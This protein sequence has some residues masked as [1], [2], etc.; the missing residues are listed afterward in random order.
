MEIIIVIAVI[1]ILA[2]V[3]IPT[4]SSIIGSSQNRVYKTNADTIYKQYVLETPKENIKKELI[5]KVG[6]NRYIVYIDGKQLR[7]IY[8][9]EQSKEELGL[10][11]HTPMDIVEG[12]ENILITSNEKLIKVKSLNQLYDGARIKIF[13]EGETNVLVMDVPVAGDVICATDTL[14]I[15]VIKLDPYNVKRLEKNDKDDSWYIIFENDDS[16]LKYRDVNE[17][18]L[19]CSETLDE[20]CQWIFKE[21]NDNIEITSKNDLN[22]LRFIRCDYVNGYNS[23][24]VYISNGYPPTIYLYNN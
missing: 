22:S 12:F 18:Y 14:N 2:A 11:P 1:A 17:H 24:F 6:E 13:Y 4:F 19:V 7:K 9:I 8:T 20:K 15:E 21:M 16:Y 3:L 10:D 23:S 5:V